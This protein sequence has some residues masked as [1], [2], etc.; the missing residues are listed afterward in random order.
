LHLA[1]WKA[2]LLM[3]GGNPLDS[4]LKIEFHVFFAAPTPKKMLNL[5]LQFV[6]SMKNDER[7]TGRK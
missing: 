7:G 6:D 2:T 5:L 1:L 4:D 3:R